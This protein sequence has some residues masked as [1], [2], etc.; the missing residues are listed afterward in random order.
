MI[1]IL[2]CHSTFAAGGKEA[3]ATRLMNAFGNDA[4]HTVLSAVPGALAARALIAPEIGVSFPEDAPSLVGK[5]G[6]RR[7]RALAD[8]MSRFDLVLTYNWGA[9]DAVM[10]R[11]LFGKAL[12]PLIHHEDGF[13]VD[14]AT[15]LRSDRNGFRRIALGG[16]HALI[17]PSQTLERIAY[18][19]WKQPAARVHRIA[20]GIDVAAYT[21]P[22][23]AI[24]GL[25]R[26]KGEVVVGTLAGLRPV[27]N[28]ARLVRCAAAIPNL[29]IVIVGEGEDR[30]AIAAEA[31]R[32]GIAHRLVMPGHLARP[33]TFIGQ[34]DIFALSSDSEQFPISLVEAMA[35]GLP[36]ACTDVGDVRAI[37]APE[38]VPFIVA[39]RNERGLHDALRTLAADAALR[40]RVGAANRARAQADY[41][42]ADMIDR[43]RA[44]YEGA[45]GA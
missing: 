23:V 28:L 45:L 15:R 9:M 32:L 19:V 16:A 43:Y 13:N 18:E 22:T 21:R 30:A 8:Y 41:G 26:R 20:N 27:K 29:R 1:R 14:E 40:H 4:R 39:P 37:V 2:H 6:F 3:R 24:P 34:F 17:V 12:P 35:A 44:L 11:R 25:Q 38:N 7:Y 36:A 5:P 31:E 10:T 33:A 42:E